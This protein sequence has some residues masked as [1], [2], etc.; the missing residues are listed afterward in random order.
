[1]SLICFPF[2]QSSGCLPH[3][4]N[5]LLIVVHNLGDPKICFRNHRPANGW[6]SG[7]VI[8]NQRQ[9]SPTSNPRVIPKT[10]EGDGVNQFSILFNEDGSFFADGSDP[11]LARH[12]AISKRPNLIVRQT[13][14][15]SQQ[16]VAN[17]LFAESHENHSSN[18]EVPTPDMQRSQFVPSA[19]SI[20]EK[21]LL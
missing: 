11:S 8:P 5:L 1:M 4:T 7:S 10:L 6:W 19:P 16:I 9:D 3:L 14:L 17:T 13:N 2:S 21:E 20:A 12:V 15:A 18:V